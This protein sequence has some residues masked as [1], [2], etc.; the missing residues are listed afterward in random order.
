MNGAATALRARAF[1]LLPTIPGV[2]SAEAVAFQGAIG[3]G[4]AD[5]ESDIDLVLAFGERALATG[6]ARGEHVV[7]GVKWSIFHLTLDSVNAKRWSDK[8]RYAYGFETE[9]VRDDRG[10][11]GRLCR[12]AHLTADERTGRL[13]H[14]IKKLA[15]RGITYRGVLGAW[16][17]F[18]LTDRADVWVGRGDLYAAHARIDQAHRLLVNLL[19]ALASRPVP[20]EKIR[21]H[22]VRA[23]PRP[24]GH[25]LLLHELGRVAALDE[26]ELDRRVGAAVELLTRCVDAADESGS[27]PEN[28]ARV[29]H[30]WFPSHSD[31]T[32]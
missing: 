31:D 3:R 5:S 27:L 14:S 22:V 9:P 25:A 29:Y 12:E 32:V 30:A 28:L 19:Y 26:H 6:A 15:N 10:R 21:H 17:G 16:R 13:V 23:L 4:E 7:D 20:S 11:L 8:Q 24:S 18:H 2:R 1:E